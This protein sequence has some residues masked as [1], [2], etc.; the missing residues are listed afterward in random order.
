MCLAEHPQA[1]LPGFDGPYYPKGLAPLVAVLAGC[2]GTLNRNTIARCSQ[3]VPG[4]A[5]ELR[6]KTRDGYVWFSCVEIR[7]ARQGMVAVAL[8]WSQDWG[9]ADGVQCDRSPAVYTWGPLGT[10]VLN[11]IIAQLAD[12]LAA[13]P[14]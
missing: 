3:G 9:C 2:R 1:K 10:S 13:C 4:F 6:P 12:A 8:P 14:V 11:G 7:V 5:S